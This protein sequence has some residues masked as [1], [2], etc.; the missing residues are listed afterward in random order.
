VVDVTGTFVRTG[1]RHRHQRRDGDAHGSAVQDPEL[2]TLY[3]QEFGR[4]KV[5]TRTSRRLQ[6]YF[7]TRN[8]GFA[9]GDPFNDIPKTVDMHDLGRAASSRTSTSLATSS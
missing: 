5:G 7:T 3:Q 1:R 8:F 4:D 2:D 9:V 6:S